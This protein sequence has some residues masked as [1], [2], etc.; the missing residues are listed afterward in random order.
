MELEE[1]HLSHLKNTKITVEFKD[2]NGRVLPSNLQKGFTFINGKEENY[3]LITPMTIASYVLL[4]TL[5]K[6]THPTGSSQCQQAL[7]PIPSNAEKDDK[8]IL[9][10]NLPPSIR[11]GMTTALL[12]LLCIPEIRIIC[13]VLL[14]AFVLWRIIWCSK[15]A[16]CMILFTRYLT[17]SSDGCARLGYYRLL[18]SSFK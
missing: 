10:S 6:R 9:W 5:I 14:F 16:Y 7:P 18:L 17:R 3:Q 12:L 1:N 11:L 8:L 2:E 13:F 4:S 15:E